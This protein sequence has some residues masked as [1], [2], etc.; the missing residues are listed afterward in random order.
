VRVFK[1]SGSAYAP[2]T[3]LSPGAWRN[4]RARWLFGRE[5][6]LSGDGHTLAIAD[7][8]D[9]GTGWGPRAAPLISGTETN[10][11]VYVY[12]LTD[13]WRLANMVKPNSN[14]NPYTDVGAF[15]DK[16]VLSQSGKTLVIGVEFE[17]SNASGIDGNWANKDRFKSGALFMY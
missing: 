17:S 16:L 8:Y 14:V 12:R 13:Q 2:V 5:I 6:A 9:N 10:G 7:V 4:D 15:T 3:T 1:R 11:A